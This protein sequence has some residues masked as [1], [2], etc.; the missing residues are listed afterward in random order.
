M[1]S[2]IAIWLLAAAASA[3]VT[4][5]PE[6]FFAAPPAGS[7][8]VV[9]LVPREDGVSA[10]YLEGASNTL[11]KQRLGETT[12]RTV[13]TSVEAVRIS[14]GIVAFQTP[15]TIFTAP[16][17]PDDSVDLGAARVLA[18]GSLI[19]FGCN[20]ARCLAQWKNGAA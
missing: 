13:L 7:Y 18:N 1:R 3:R 6:K 15:G 12:A 9:A 20:D 10:F 16:L 4:L 11:Y 14:N 5:G 8:S 2:S 19:A 17:L